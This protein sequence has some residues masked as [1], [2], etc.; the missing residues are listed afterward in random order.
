MNIVGFPGRNPETE[1][2]MK[3][4]LVPLAS[5]DR[6]A[7][8]ARYS[9]WNAEGS[10]E[11]MP[12]VALEAARCSIGQDDLVVAK[13]MGTMVLLAA[14]ALDQMPARAVLIGTPLKGYSESQMRELKAL[15][16]TIPCLFIQQTDDFTGSHAQ[17]LSSVGSDSTMTTVRQVEG[18]D[19]IYSDTEA[20]TAL[21]LDWW[22]PED[23]HRG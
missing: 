8:I 18:A 7:V 3:T 10:A 22:Q 13:S 20:L 15:S 14:I 12:D 23:A 11:G 4:L 5:A 6:T 21:I 9:H 17:V 19:H 16:T 2:W 1:S